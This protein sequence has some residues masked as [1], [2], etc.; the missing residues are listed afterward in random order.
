ML[1]LSGILQ[2][3]RALDWIPADPMAEVTIVADPGANPNFNVLTPK[4]VEEVADK[5]VLVARDVRRNTPTSAPKD[6]K[7]QAPEGPPWPIDA[8]DRPSSRGARPPPAGATL[9]L[10][11]AQLPAGDHALRVVVE[12]AAGEYPCRSLR[13]QNGDRGIERA[14]GRERL[15]PGWW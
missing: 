5:M 10:D 6:V 4:Q 11:T 8:A 14:R 9:A 2:R 1:V 7:F 12:D 15:P 3:A 13:C